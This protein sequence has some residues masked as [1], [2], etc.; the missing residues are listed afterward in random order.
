MEK[1]ERK[2]RRGQEGDR[3]REKRSRDTGKRKHGEERWTATGR[4]KGEIKETRKEVKEEEG[5]G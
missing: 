1:S 4:S 5:K 3:E 2:E